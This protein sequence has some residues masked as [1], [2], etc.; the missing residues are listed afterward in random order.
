MVTA[1]AKSA[2]PGRRSRG[3]TV[4]A[5]LLS[6]KTAPLP[7][8][9]ALI[10]ARIALAWIFIYHGGRRLFGW[11]G[12]I[13]LDK[14]ATYFANVAH[15]HPGTFWALVSGIIELGGG[16]ALAFGFASRLAGAAIFGDMMGAIITVTAANGFN[17]AVPGG[18]VEVN[19]AFGVLAFVIAMLGAGRFS[20]DA[21]LERRL[22]LREPT[23][24]A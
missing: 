5:A 17:A 22:A 13:G 19:L 15:L 18:G 12:G 8:D 4:L 16:I 6:T 7:T 2:A 24:T 10:A 20:V 14:S 23:S 3:R 9:C 1:T 21:V 11:F